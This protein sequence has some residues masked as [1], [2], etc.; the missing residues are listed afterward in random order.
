VESL[1]TTQ[2]LKPLETMKIE[3]TL[4]RFAERLCEELRRLAG[5]E[6]HLKSISTGLNNLAQI[7]SQPQKIG[8]DFEQRLAKLESAMDLL[9]SHVQMLDGRVISQQQDVSL[10]KLDLENR[11]G[12]QLE[13][14]QGMVDRLEASLTSNW[15][16]RRNEMESKHQEWE[17]MAQQYQGL[18]KDPVSSEMA[19]ILKAE[20]KWLERQKNKLQQQR[21]NNEKLKAV[22]EERFRQL[23][24]LS[25]DL[26][27]TAGTLQCQQQLLQE[28]LQKLDQKV[29]KLNLK[30]EQNL[31]KSVSIS[32]L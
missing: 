20:L 7:Q 28:S 31:N 2:V 13:L 8:I 11:L 16:K 18:T 30:Q 1:S 24:H 4:D 27:G 15:D 6:D 3:Q 10:M 17:R 5:G 21:E 19:Q 14:M 22:I 12:K 25:E 9:N 23:T 29:L 32:F 26:R